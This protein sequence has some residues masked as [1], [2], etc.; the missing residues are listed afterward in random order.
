MS[1]LKAN[2]SVEKAFDIFVKFYWTIIYLAVDLNFGIRYF[3]FGFQG[4]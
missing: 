1:Y 2:I 4:K 3:H